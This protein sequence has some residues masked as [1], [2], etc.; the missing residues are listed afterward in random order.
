MDCRH[1]G[2]ELGTSYLTQ[3][4]TITKSAKD[5][6]EKK[7]KEDIDNTRRVSNRRSAAAIRFR[8]V[9]CCRLS[10]RVTND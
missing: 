4:V 7:E 9:E 8:R 5:S 10:S 1:Q 3:A 6:G 2:A